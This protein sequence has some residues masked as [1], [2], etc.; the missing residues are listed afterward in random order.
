ML[1]G[2]PLTLNM[3]GIKLPKEQVISIYQWLTLRQH[4][5]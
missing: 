3:G 2:K 1:L 5:F 4:L